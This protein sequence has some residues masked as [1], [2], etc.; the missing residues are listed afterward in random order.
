MSLYTTLDDYAR[1]C[2]CNRDT[3]SRRLRDVPRSGARKQRFLLAHV[4]PSLR[5]RRYAAPLTNAARDDGAFFCGGDDAFPAARALEKFMQADPEM[6]TR[7]HNVRV[8]FFNALATSMRSSGLIRDAERHRVMLPMSGAVLPYIVT[9]D[10]RGLPVMADFARSF[11]IVHSGGAYES[12][13][14]GPEG[15]PEG[16]QAA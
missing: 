7:L 2:G 14:I 15:L 6:A 11:A 4:L 1:A 10:K 12:E 16:R 9:G 3:A 5:Y 8:T 13:L